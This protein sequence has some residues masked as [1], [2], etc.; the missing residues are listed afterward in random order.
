MEGMKKT[1][2][3]IA[4]AFALAPPLALACT[5][6]GDEDE[7]YV[8]PMEKVMYYWGALENV[9]LESGW[10]HYH[11]MY[12]WQLLGGSVVGE[13]F[14][15]ESESGTFRF[16]PDI[17]RSEYWKSD[18][19]FITKPDKEPTGMADL[20]HPFIFRGALELPPGP[21]AEV[22]RS[23]IELTL[24]LRGVGSQC[25]EDDTLR[26]WQ[27][28]SEL[29]RGWLLGGGPIRAAKENANPDS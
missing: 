2:M 19:S 17:A 1:A 9:R 11:E 25:L 26:R 13:A 4:C 21:A 5:C 20:L 29:E 3:A 22:G 18:S 24:V 23:A 6:C 27:V 8:H 15:F 10:L 12:G 28:T 16:V 7:Q 14:A